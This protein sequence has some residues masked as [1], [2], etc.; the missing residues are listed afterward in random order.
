MSSAMKGV[1]LVLAVTLSSWSTGYAQV[2]QDA[3][4]GRP[5]AIIDLATPEGSGLVKGQWRY[6]DTKIIEVERDRKPTEPVSHTY[7]LTPQAGVKGFDDHLWEVIPS[8]TLDQRRGHGRLSFNW[9]RLNLTIPEKIG[10]FDPTGATVILEVVVDDYA[11]VWVDGNLPQ[12]LGQTGGPLIKGFNAPNR[13]VVGRQV[14][15]GQQIQLA[16]FGGNGPLSKPPRNFIWIR[17][18]TL[19]FYKPTQLAPPP[20]DLQVQRLDPTLDAILPRDA[21]LEKLAGGFQFTE[22][23]VWVPEGYL[24]FSDPNQNTIYRWS[25]DG[26][27]AVFRTKSGY[28]GFDIGAYGQPGSNGLTLDS[29]SRLTINEHGRHRVTRLEKNGV[30]TVLAD[31][32]QGKR[33][34]SPNDLVYRSNGDLYFTDPPFGLPKFDDD[35]RKELPYSGIFG[36]LQG[37]LKLLSTD[38]KG[39]NGLAFSPDERYLYVDNWDKKKKVVMRYE[40][41]TDGTLAHGTV[42]FDMTQAPGEDALDGLKVDQAGNV[43]VSGPGGLWILSPEGKHL[44]T[45]DGPEHPHN[46][47]WG[48]EDG[49]TLYWTA[50]TGLYRLRLNI[51]GIRPGGKPQAS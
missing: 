51:P 13:I 10:N 15:P 47:A 1:L 37:Q 27:V 33:L 45:L 6:S 17:S 3:P 14:K 7:D 34:N 12:V 49:K 19:D 26:Q 50:R 8:N 16:I 18:A 28:S 23:P 9:Y 20:V 36:I 40:V 48:D 31:R 39:P 21:K 11:E 38:L 46:F 44:G 24:L 2:T 41:Q 42:F 25:P 30:V 5:E 29:E 4:A 22:G 43:Y 32:Y 35:P